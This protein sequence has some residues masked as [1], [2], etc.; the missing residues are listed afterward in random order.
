MRA[1]AVAEHPDNRVHCLAGRAEAIPLA[2]ASCDAA[3]LLFVLHHVADLEAAASELSR[4]LRVGG[5]VL[6]AG[7]FSERLH[8][9]TYYRY[10]PRARE[11]ESK[12]FPRLADVAG[13]FEKAGLTIIGFDEVEH[14]VAD[15]LASYHSRLGY[16]AIS[17]FEHLTK[18]EINEGLSRLSTDAD[19]ENAPQPVRHVHDLVT[20]SLN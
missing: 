2:A 17:T 12:L 14:I 6:V 3:L 18:D 8:P 9:R 19:A 16:R 7:S 1:I 13:I 4:V 5:R 15:S 20:F 10:L 11:V